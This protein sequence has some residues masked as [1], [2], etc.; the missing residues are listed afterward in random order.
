MKKVF[1]ISL[2]FI[3]FLSSTSFADKDWTKVGFGAV[4]C[5]LLIKYLNERDMLED[6]DNEALVSWIQG[7]VTGINVSNDR[8][9]NIRPDWDGVV[10]EVIKRCKKEPMNN[11]LDEID[12]IYKNKIK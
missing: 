3:S 10:L 9:L 7:Y 6:D 5:S 2:V 4:P 12:W 8:I 1:I 11:V